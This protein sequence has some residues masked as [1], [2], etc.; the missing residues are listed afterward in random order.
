M[1]YLVVPLV[2]GLLFCNSCSSSI[3]ESNED[4]TEKKVYKKDYEYWPFDVDEGILRCNRG[5]EVV[6]I[7]HGRTYAVN[8]TAK[9]FAKSQGYLDMSEIWVGGDVG[10]IIKDGVKLCDCTCRGDCPNP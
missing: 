4:K 9:N 5:C 10:D 3:K 7:A 8:G 1:K 6:F 2:L